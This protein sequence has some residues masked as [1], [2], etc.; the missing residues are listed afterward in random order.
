MS[1][2]IEKQKRQFMDFKDKYKHKSSCGIYANY[3]HD[4]ESIFWI[5]IWTMFIYR[6]KTIELTDL[7]SICRQK[8]AGSKLFSRKR[9]SI[10]NRTDFLTSE[11]RFIKQMEFIPE[12]FGSLKK[13]ATAFKDHLL[14]VYCEEEHNIAVNV[15][16]TPRDESVHKSTLEIFRLY[17][18][19]D[20]DNGLMLTLVDSQSC[21]KC[22]T[23]VEDGEADKKQAK[24]Q[25]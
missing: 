18:V 3:L 17:G 19:P 4:L 1:I 11:E 24:K 16:I 2:E 7:E 20:G 5:L 12:Y 23:P 14:K 13:L 10:I 6:K 22:L 25:R 8:K 9:A 21:L 15:P